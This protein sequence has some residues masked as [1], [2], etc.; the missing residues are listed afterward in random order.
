MAS[1]RLLPT[2]PAATAKAADS[3]RPRIGLESTRGSVL[4]WKQD[5]RSVPLDPWGHEYQY[6]YP[7]TKNTEASST[8]YDLFSIGKDN[9]P[10][11][12]DDIGNW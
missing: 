7:G 1:A 2:C 6:R 5:E 12:E 4:E 9:K 3:T 11:T 8:P 10:D